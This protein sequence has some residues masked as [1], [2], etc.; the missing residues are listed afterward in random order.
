[1]NKDFNT[2]KT[3]VGKNVMD[4]STSMASIIGV[5]LNNRYFDLLRRVNWQSIDDDYSFSTVAGTKDYVLP[6]NF[7]KEIYVHDS[8]NKSQ[9]DRMTLQ[10]WIDKYYDAESDQ[11][12]PTKYIILDQ[13]VRDQPSSASQL[14]ITS[15]ST[16][17]TTETVRI[18]GIDSNGVELDESVTL[19]GT[20]AQ[21]SANTYSEVLA[22]S[23]SD[24]TVGRVTVTS[25]SG[26]VTIALLSP[27]VLESRATVMRLYPVPSTVCTIKAPYIVKPTPLSNSY[28]YPI[29]D[30]ADIIEYGATA[31]AWRYKRQFAK[32][33]EFE[34]L[35]EKFI[36]T[37]IWD[38][39]NQP[40]QVHQFNPITYNRDGLV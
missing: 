39:E 32:A 36:I 11:A 16:S 37:F 15:S 2:L 4:T 22:I 19:N 35:Y 8:T 21:T 13:T 29:I 40:N 31:D 1:M 10:E 7:G 38:K 25:N 12:A 27:S 18:K 3:N 26:T 34:R 6:Y 23:K 20:S 14:S 33:N 28:D 30:C 24:A 9:L 5:Y 17:D